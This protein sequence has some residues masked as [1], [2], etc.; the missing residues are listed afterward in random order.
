MKITIK[1]STDKKFYFVIVANNGEP[2]AVSETYKN[3]K[4]CIRTATLIKD[5]AMLA[6]I[7]DIDNDLIT[8]ENYKSDYYN[9][10]TFEKTEIE[11]NIPW[12]LVEEVKKTLHSIDGYTATPTLIDPENKSVVFGVMNSDNRSLKYKITINLND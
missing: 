4:D 3:K 5:K 8:M 7:V 6:E 11:T 10:E 1:K 12:D 9:P 2:I